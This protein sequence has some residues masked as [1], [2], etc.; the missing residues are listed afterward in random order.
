[1]ASDNVKQVRYGELVLN[2]FIL[3][4]ELLY[5]KHVDAKNVTDWLWKKEEIFLQMSVMRVQE[6]QL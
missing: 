1:M 3:N 5:M 4:M 6:L 2:M